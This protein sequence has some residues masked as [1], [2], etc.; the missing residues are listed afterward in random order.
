MFICQDVIGAAETG[1][2][3]TLAFGLPILQRLLEEQEKTARMFEQKGE[4][5]ER[6][7]PKGFLRALIITPT[8]ELALQVLK[9]ALSV[10]FVHVIFQ[11]P[12]CTNGIKDSLICII[13][14]NSIECGLVACGFIYSD[15][16]EYTHTLGFLHVCLDIVT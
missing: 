8:R 3:K 6:N 15:E 4:E 12:K 2:G 7:A 13:G 1:S 11:L 9:N 14:P 16:I 10:T 5:A